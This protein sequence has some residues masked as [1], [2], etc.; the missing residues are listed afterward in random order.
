[1]PATI[2]RSL[3]I[4]LI[5]LG[6]GLLLIVA[7]CGGMLAWF[8]TYPTVSDKANRRFEYAAEPLPT[9]MSV[10]E[11]SIIEGG[12]LFREVIF[13]D[14]NG[15][16]VPAGANMRLWVYLPTGRTDIGALPCVLICGAGSTLLEGMRLGEEDQAEHLPYVDAGLAVIAYDLDGSSL[17]GDETERYDAFR[18]AEAGLVNARIALDYA[19][20][21]V[22]EINA[23][24]IFSVGHSSAATM[25]LLL[26][27][28]E[29][30]IAGCIAYAPAVDLKEVYTAV[31]VRTLSARLPELADFIVRSSPV[32]HQQHLNCPTMIF[33]SLQDDNVS[34]D[35]NRTFQKRQSSA[36]T[37]CTLVEVPT[38]D[39]YA[40]MIQEGI[41]AG[42]EWLKQHLR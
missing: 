28:H 6:V 24:Q 21:S 12:V 14:G 22:P 13:G 36:G 27:A 33:Q 25:A 17:L 2:S 18:D 34:L 1:M 3:T 10:G 37:E 16:G 39:H 30:R 41:P 19:I 15:Y 11:T 20:T 32:T 4:I 8:M 38:G 35:S 7:A 40:S 26:A 31:L 9:K 29:P 5:A 42:I 23:Q